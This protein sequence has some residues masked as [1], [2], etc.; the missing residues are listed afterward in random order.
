MR[1]LIINGYSSESRERLSEAGMT[2]ASGLHARMLHRFEPDAVYDVLFPS[3]SDVSLPSIDDLRA[4]AGIMWTGCDKSLADPHDRDSQQQLNI[5]RKILEAEVPCW[6]T[7]WGLQIMSVAAGGR[8]ERNPNGREIGLARKIK[9][10][11]SGHSHPMYAGKKAVFDAF[12][13]H[14]DIVTRVPSEAAVLACSENSEVQAMTFS[15]GK[16][17]FWGVQYHPDYDIHE[18]ARLMIARK[19]VLISEGF[20]ADDSDFEWHIQRME[21]LAQYPQNKHLRW[22]LGL[23]DDVLS[24]GIRQREFS[25]WLKALK[26]GTTDAHG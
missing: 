18:V 17:V 9:V 7:C 10:T 14:S 16:G 15:Y 3:D 20:F 12:A 23:D 4:Y 19:E 22:Q 24:A 21:T 13:S 11:P 1:Y 2:L 26:I 8:V 6:G 25:N 5:A